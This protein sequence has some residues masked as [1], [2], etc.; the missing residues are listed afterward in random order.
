MQS[1][2]STNLVSRLYR[3]GARL[4]GRCDHL[5]D[6]TAV[7]AGCTIHDRHYAGIQTVPMSRIRGSEGR[8]NDFDA[9]FHPLQKHT[10]AR[11]QSIASAHERNIPLPPVELIRVGEVYFVRDGH[12]RISVARLRGQEEME[13]R[14]VELRTN[15]P[16]TP[17]L[18]R[19]AL[20]RKGAQSTFVM[21]SDL[22]R[23]RPGAEIPVE[24]SEPTVYHD[25]KK[26]IEGHRYF[27][28]LAR[29][30][31]VSLAEAV[32]HW[33]DQLYLPQ[34]TVIRRS[35]LVQA[36]GNR[37][38]TCLYLAIM[39]H[40]YYMSERAGEDP[41]PEAAVRD[42]VFHFGPWQARRQMSR[43]EGAEASV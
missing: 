15:V 12:H 41:G 37:T 6:L 4:I 39:E 9:N 30:G 26:H 33:Y 2:H 17:D 19:P 18:D 5:L 22:L 28:R 32:V 38:E 20:V 3:M 43:Q 1:K 23:L 25:L 24:A 42:Y 10:S 21:W 40:R 13:A 11:W 8:C 35:G 16:L 36:F 7:T 34:V 29:G 27:M 31:E 14:S